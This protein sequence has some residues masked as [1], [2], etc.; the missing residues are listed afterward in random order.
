MDGGLEM[1]TVTP[2]DFFGFRGFFNLITGL[3][4]SGFF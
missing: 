4:N 1:K 2:D 3:I